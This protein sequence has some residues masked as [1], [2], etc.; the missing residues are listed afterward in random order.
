MPRS[1]MSRSNMPRSKWLRAAP[2]G[3]LS[4]ACLILVLQASASRMLKIDERNIANPGLHS[5]P[6]QM[7]AW[8]AS[9]E[10]SMPP[11]TEAYLKPDEYIMRDY[12]NDQ[13]RAIGLF[14]AYFKSLQ[15]SYGPHSPSV[16]L[17]GAG[18]LVSSSKI[19]NIPVAGRTEGIPVNSYTMEKSG[20]RLLVLYWYQNDRDIWAQEFH[21]K[22]R[23]L[24]DLVRYHRSDVSLVRLITPLRGPSS[25]EEFNNCVQFTQR[26]FPL[27]AERF[28]SVH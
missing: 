9:A 14:V 21:A 25:E 7:G 16:C 10:Q 2:Y 12:M 13:G 18:W 8:K 22:L 6:W 5:L 17:P 19:V 4:A 28:A 24:P 15:N 26:M 27:L 3:I 20:E 1:N 23:L 11:T